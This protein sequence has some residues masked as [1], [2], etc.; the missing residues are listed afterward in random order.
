MFRHLNECLR[1]ETEQ[2][3]NLQMGLNNIHTDVISSRYS[4]LFYYAAHTVWNSSAP[5]GV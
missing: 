5:L 1:I 4:I 3:Y 2:T